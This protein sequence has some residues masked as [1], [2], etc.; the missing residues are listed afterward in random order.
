MVGIRRQQLEST[1]RQQGA[2]HR[3]ALRLPL[4]DHVFARAVVFLPAEQRLTAWRHHDADQVAGVGQEGGGLRHRVGFQ[5]QILAGPHRLAEIVSQ[6]AGFDVAARQL[7]R[8]E[9]VV[10]QRHLGPGA[11][12]VGAQL[13]LEAV[14]GG[15]RNRAGRN[16]K[17]RPRQQ[18]R[19]EH[20][21]VPVLAGIAGH[22]AFGTGFD[23]IGQFVV[24]GRILAPQVVERGVQRVLVAV[25]QQ[26]A[27]L[28]GEPHFPVAVFDAA[29]GQ[30]QSGGQP[31]EQRGVLREA[32]AAG[33]SG[34]F[35]VGVR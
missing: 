31:G 24:G 32:A 27:H 2:E 21:S 18:R 4:L 26:P 15:G 14:E 17:A 16:G 23:E 19:G 1:G 22:A 12:G 28:F 7:V 9:Q 25:G 30:R 10:G 33:E 13:H 35:H 6:V 3:A 11:E 8:A 20:D 5:L 34:A 29:G